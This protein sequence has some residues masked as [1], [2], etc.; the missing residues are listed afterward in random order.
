MLDGSGPYLLA[1]VPA[2]TWSLVGQ[3]VPPG[4]G[5]GPAPAYVGARSPI[6]VGC[7]TDVR[8]DLELKPV[9]APD[10]PLCRA[11]ADVRKHALSVLTAELTGRC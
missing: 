4:R 6:T 3:A 10:P 7:G 9:H 11:L 8:A 2:G 5:E 1:A